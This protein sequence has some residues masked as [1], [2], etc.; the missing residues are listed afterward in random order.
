ME[1]EVPTTPAPV[2]EVIRRTVVGPER[3]SR[4]GRNMRR[5]AKEDL[6][7]HSHNMQN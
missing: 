6:L 4:S 5:V 2:A 7:F 3:T 1:K